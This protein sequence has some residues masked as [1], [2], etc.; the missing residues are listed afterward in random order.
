MSTEKY[1]RDERS[2]HQK[3][4][5]VSKVMS[6]NKAKN[7]KP[8]LLLRRSLWKNHLRGYRVNYK[9]IPGRPDVAF[10][11]KMI[12]IFVNGCFLLARKYHEFDIIYNN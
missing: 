1:I 9:K 5:N 11:A 3:N 4:E 6:A 2:P 7:T 10:P 12:A 8:E